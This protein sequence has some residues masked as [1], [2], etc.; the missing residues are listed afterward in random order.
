MKEYWYM[1]AI[2]LYTFLEKTQQNVWLFTTIDALIIINTNSTSLNH[3]D[4]WPFDDSYGKFTCV[5][6]IGQCEN[7]IL[8]G[9]MKQSANCRVGS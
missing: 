4:L 5:N 3:Y 8:T 1:L 7:Y 2:D 6:E 9:R